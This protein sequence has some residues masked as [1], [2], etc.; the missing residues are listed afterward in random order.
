MTILNQ[1]DTVILIID[2]Q[3]RLLNSIFNKETVSKNSVIIA[4]TAKILNIPIIVTEQYPRGLGYTAEILKSTLPDNTLFYEKLAFNAL[5]NPK[6]LDH[7]RT[8]RKKQIVVFGIETHICINQTVDKLIEYGYE[9]NVVSDACGSRS[10]YEHNAGI[11]RIRSNNGRIITT[12][13]ALFEWVKSAKH[14][15][16]KEVQSLIL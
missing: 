7:L 16:F 13:M 6:L 10:E 15:K 12:E 4:K 11:D 1:N 2:I 3:E 5:D 8:T 9:A 14:P